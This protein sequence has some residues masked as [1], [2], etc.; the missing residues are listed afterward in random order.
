MSR[1]PRFAASAPPDHDGLVFV[2]GTELHH[3]RDV[4]RLRAGAPVT[5]TTPDGAAYAG[6]LAGYNRDR[7]SIR[8]VSRSSDAR[9]APLVLAA[10]IIKGPRMDV[11]VEK[12]AELGAAELWPIICAHSVA[13]AAGG[14]RLARWRR[15][16]A[17][18]AKQS[19]APRALEVREPRQFADLIRDAPRDTLRVIC[20]I[21]AQPLG[22]VLARTRPKKILLACGPEGDFDRAERAAARD[23]GFIEAGLGANRLRSETAAIAAL[24]IAGDFLA[25]AERADSE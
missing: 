16:A 24:S 1:P 18:A 4:M 25:G 5:V 22:M 6:V 21:G 7:G 8:I 11:L 14:E 23:A 15:I 3:L 13:R 2:A 19:L 9:R 17:A 12:A 10:A 20:A